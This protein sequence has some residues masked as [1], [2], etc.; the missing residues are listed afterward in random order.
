MGRAERSESAGLIRIGTSKRLV[1]QC[2]GLVA[3]G[4]RLW[5]R[6]HR[7]AYPPGCD[8]RV[9]ILEPFG[10]GDVISLEPLIRLLQQ[11]HFKV[12]LC[13]RPE[14]QPLYPSIGHWMAAQVPWARHQFAQKY[15]WAEYWRQPFRSFVR[16]LRG[17]A[18]G[19]VGLDPRGDIRSVLLLHLAGCR[20]V[21]TLSSYLGSDLSLPRCAAERIPFSPELRR[22]ELNMRFLTA[23]VGGA[24][25][26]VG[27]PQF[28]HLAPPA[29]R[30]S[31][32]RVGLVP[33]APWPGK[34]WAADKW[35][36][37]A[38]QLQQRGWDV[39]ALCGPGQTEAAVEQTGH[40]VPVVQCDSVLAW[41]EALGRC[42]VVV[43][44]DTGPMHLADALG[45]PVVALFG[46]GLLP[47][48]APSGRR[49][50]VIT[51]RD[52]DFVPCHP[53]EANVPL[54]RKYMDRISVS[55]VLEAVERVSSDA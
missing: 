24:V 20:R 34:L 28:P 55:E 25:P 27:P 16:A 6:C 46:Q 13:A 45:V 40:S 50:C 43:T 44:L 26:K 41:A 38:V 33:V 2:F 47:F 37:L 17:A 21:L 12:I 42:A 18:A 39:Q 1:A 49:S 8:R 23:L 32:R 51:H 5:R 36:E 11:Q 48:W 14:W 22:W 9:L 10:L 53:T 15:H 54:G 4:L 30:S 3:G 19:A 35:K 52:A 29:P 31:Q 7:R